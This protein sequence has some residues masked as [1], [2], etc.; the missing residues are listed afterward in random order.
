MASR[1]DR[2]NLGRWNAGLIRVD[3]GRDVRAARANAGISLRTAGAAADMSHA[4][5]GRIE[6]GVLQNLTVDQASRA[7]AAV[8]LR[9][10][11]RAY[12]DGGPVADAPQLALLG[13]FRA[14]LPQAAGWA[15]EVP[16]AIP[17]DRRAWDAVVT[18]AGNRIA[19]EAEARLRDIQALERRIALK[20]RDDAVAVVILLV[21]ATTTNRRVLAA[22]REALRSR[23]PLDGHAILAAL[24]AGRAPASGGIVLL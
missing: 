1:N 5:F 19:V 11:A 16:L 12:P 17:G 18:L 2:A 20:Q 6:R 9:L 8:G 15:T 14:R 23:F 4:Q 22:H 10:V 13:R 21:N 24:R 3:I 7:C